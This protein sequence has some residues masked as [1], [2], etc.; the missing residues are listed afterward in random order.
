MHTVC[1]FDLPSRTK[2]KMHAQRM[3]NA[4]L[5]DHG[6]RHDASH[7]GAIPWV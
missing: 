6:P 3:I 2:P 5:H 4:A 1:Y 7:Y